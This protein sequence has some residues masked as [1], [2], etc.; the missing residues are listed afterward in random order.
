MPSSPRPTDGSL[1][2]PDPRDVIAAD[3]IRFRKLSPTDR[4]RELF[5]MRT[6]GTKLAES[7]ARRESI[8]KLEAAEEERWQAIQRELFARH[9]H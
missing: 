7:S 5:A 3:A 4:W 6:W 2:F 9:G 8:R 1:V